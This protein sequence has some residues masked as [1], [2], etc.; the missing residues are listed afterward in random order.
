LWESITND[1]F[2]GYTEN[3]TRVAVPA[4]DQAIANK[5][6]ACRLDAVCPET[7]GHLVASLQ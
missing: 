5:I 4:G 2:F 1:N 7:K 3:Y 6:T